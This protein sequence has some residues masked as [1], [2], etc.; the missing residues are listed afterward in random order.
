MSSTPA[1]PSNYAALAEL[2]KLANNVVRFY[3]STTDG[4]SSTLDPFVSFAR[5]CGVYVKTLTAY[6]LLAPVLS[7]FHSIPFDDLGPPL[8]NTI[9]VLLSIPFSQELL[10]MWSHI[11]PRISRSPPSSSSTFDKLST[12]IT[13]Q[14]GRLSMDSIRDSI[15]LSVD[16]QPHFSRRRSPSPT[17]TNAEDPAAL[18]ARL[19]RILDTFFTSRLPPS[20][21]VDEERNDGVVLDE[22]LPPVFLLLSHGVAGSGEIK[23]FVQAQLLPPN[24]YVPPL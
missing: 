2:L 6:S 1:T 15:S 4:W 9:H 13:N 5:P 3:P 18:P 12:M 17:N 11:P 21:S 19:L 14:T 7:T 23:R 8:T 24:L 22:M 10:P 16:R 20:R